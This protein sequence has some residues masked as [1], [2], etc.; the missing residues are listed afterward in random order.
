MS[1]LT[2]LNARERKKLFAQL[3]MQFG[4]GEGGLKRYALL[5]NEKS[6]RI[7]AVNEE[8]VGVLP[9]KVRVDALGLYVATRLN[10]GEMRLSVEGSQLVGP[11]AA[12]N[13]VDINK[14]QFR[15]W[16]R[17]EALTMLT[18]LRGFV[19]VRHGDDWCGCGK[20]VQEKDG[21]AI[22]NY[23]PK[24]RWVHGN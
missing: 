7:Y 13:V 10:T 16:M 8:L 1:N 19:L 18:E 5:V 4:G 12:T 3:D 9:E 24:T 14:E 20:V 21:T 11:H 15:H 2:I 17:G 6:G 23:V 22:H